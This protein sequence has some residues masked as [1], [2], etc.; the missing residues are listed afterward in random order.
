VN[1]SE[2]AGSQTM[3]T[4]FMLCRQAIIS[5]VTCQF[6]WK[7]V[8]NFYSYSKTK[9]DKN[10]ATRDTLSLAQFL[11]QHQQQ[12]QMPFSSPENRRLWQEGHKTGWGCGFVWIAISLAWQPK[13]D[14]PIGTI[15]V[16]T[17]TK[18]RNMAS[19]NVNYTFLV[20]AHP[21]MLAW[22]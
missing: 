4:V 9:T 3:W 17:S 21:W 2:T 12:Y 18:S 19:Q 15:S 7:F 22:I 14:G 20:T 13:W 1:Y 11:S 8:N 6:W 10:Q 16:P 5:R